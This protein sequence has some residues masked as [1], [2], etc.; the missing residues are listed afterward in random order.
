MRLPKQLSVVAIET[1]NGAA[2]LL[3]DGLSNENAVA[4]DHW[5][6]VAVL[7]QGRAPTRIFVRAPVQGQRGLF[8]NARSL[9]AAPSRPV[10]GQRRRAQ[11]EPASYWSNDVSQHLRLEFCE[12]PEDGQGECSL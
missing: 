4:P 1:K 8:G 9:R 6:R 10:V 11:S 12:Q 3:F 2:V 5:S 7:G